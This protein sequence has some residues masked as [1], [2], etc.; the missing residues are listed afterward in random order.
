MRQIKH[1]EKNSSGV[2]YECVALRHMKFGFY[3]ES[4]EAFQKASTM[5]SGTANVIQFNIYYATLKARLGN[6]DEAEKIISYAQPFYNEGIMTKKIALAFI[7]TMKKDYKKAISMKAVDGL[8]DVTGAYRDY[9]VALITKVLDSYA[10]AA[11]L[12]EAT[13]SFKIVNEELKSRG[14]PP[15]L[16]LHYALAL[17]KFNKRFG[18]DEIAPLQDAIAS[19][20]V[21]RPTAASGKDYGYWENMLTVYDMT[22]AS[23][24]S[25]EQYLDALNTVEKARSRRFLDDLGNKKLGAKGT[26]SLMTQRATETLDALSMLEAD[27]VETA[28][29]AE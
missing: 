1:Q 9:Y 25:K 3:R 10:E 7:Y 8:D 24:Y 22:I 27:M 2:I 15:S 12:D 23:Q 6:F 26:A 29:K 20:E 18:K 13:K 4:E 5:I 19:L 17:S 21:T 16:M 28:Q 14:N 11:S